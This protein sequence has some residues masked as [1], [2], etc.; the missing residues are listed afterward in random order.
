M[1][2]VIDAV[3]EM[4]SHETDKKFQEAMMEEV[5]KVRKQSKKIKF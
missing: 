2:K 4:T 1:D 5:D 3:M